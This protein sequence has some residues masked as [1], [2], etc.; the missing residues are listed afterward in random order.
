[1]KTGRPREFDLDAALDGALSVFQ[2]HGYEGSSV[3]ELTEAM[4]INPPSLYAAFGNK[5]GLFRKALDRYAVRRTAFWDEALK[6]ASARRMVEVLL[7]ETALFLTEQCSP[8][9]SLF[10]RSMVSCSAATEAIRRELAARGAA[11]ELALRERLERARES[12][13]MPP[14]LRPADFARYIVTVLE[15]MSVQASGGATGDELLRVADMTLRIWPST[16]NARKAQTG[17]L[18]VEA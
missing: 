10:V 8:P 18:R 17:P 1:L 14:N 7:R 15:G 6:M 3:A 9:G 16:S 2:R 5:E 13:E 11:G 4:G 12:G